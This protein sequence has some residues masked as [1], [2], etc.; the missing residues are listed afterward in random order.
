MKRIKLDESLLELDPKEVVDINDN[1]LMIFDD[2]DSMGDINLPIM[3]KINAIRKYIM[4]LGRAKNVSIII[5]SHDI[6]HIGINRDFSRKVMNEMHDITFFNKTA[7]VHQLSHCLTKYFG[8]K[9]NEIDSLRTY[10][11]SRWTCVSKHFPRYILREK[12][13]IMNC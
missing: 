6:T 7:N 12:D 13:C 2:V 3:R 9:Q 5:A 1:S 8:M 4:E 11:R 10:P